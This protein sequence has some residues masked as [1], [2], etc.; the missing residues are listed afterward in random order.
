MSSVAVVV[1]N[2]NGRAFIGPA[3]ESILAQTHPDFHVVLVDDAST[4]GSA[5]YAAERW[6]QITVHALPA[7]V[8][9]T[10]A[11]NR[12]LA[13]ARHGEFVALLN[14]DLELDPEWL[15]RATAALE[16]DPGLA[17]VSGKMLRYDDRSTID[18]A[19]DQL[20][21]SG[22]ALNRGAGETDAGQY[23]E[24]AEV[25]SA[26]AGAALYRRSAL[27]QV[28]GFD[29]DLVAYLEDVDWGFR[30]RLQG[31]RALYV[32]EAVAFH[33]GGATTSRRK[34]FFARLQR[35]NHLI[36]MIKNVPAGRLARWLPLVVAYQV[37]W[38][39]ASVR[40]GLGVEHLR[41][42]RDFGRALPGVLRK[43]RTVQR[44]VRVDAAELD[45]AMG[46]GLPEGRLAALALQLAPQFVSRRR[47]RR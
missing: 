10:A 29:E 33:M 4:D 37:A 24:R 34:G 25:F 30:A 40:D 42:W 8:G 13:A 7:N 15:R 1:L 21:P 38:F 2:Y 9:V 3:I 5:A 11:M 12:G 35:R 28:G 17:S 26:C 47:A 45:R 16:A 27:E 20:L 32:P 6:P 14:N 44:S 46:L 39:A 36:V 22:V 18:A 43:R 41:A 31:W 19:G 23:D